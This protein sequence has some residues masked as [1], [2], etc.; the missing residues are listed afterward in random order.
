MKKIICLLAVVTVLGGTGIGCGATGKDAVKRDKS[1]AVAPPT[2]NLPAPRL[3]RTAPLMLALKNRRS[4]RDFSDKKLSM[5]QISDILWAANGINRPDGKHTSPSPM[6]KQGV[7][8]YAVTA[9]GAFLYD[10]AKH[11]L[12][13][14]ATGDLRKEMGKQDFVAVAA[15]NLAYVA[16][17]SV[18]GADSAAIPVGCMV[19]NV[20]LYCATEGLANVPRGWFDPASVSKALL[21]KSTQTPILTQTVGYPKESVPASPVPKP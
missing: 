2:I 21:L 11:A 16:D 6:H 4:E 1:E 20:G 18:I 17:T 9:E 10:T 12:V 15:L 3:D 19:Q 5:E 8:I 14:V 7:D 13:P